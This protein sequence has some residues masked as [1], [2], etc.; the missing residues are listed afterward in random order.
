MQHADLVTD[1]LWE[2]VAPFLPKEPP[3]PTGARVP[4]RAARAGIVFV[5]LAPACP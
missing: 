2:A 4:D 5:F 3:T 1:D